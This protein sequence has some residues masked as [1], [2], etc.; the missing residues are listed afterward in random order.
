MGN[1][2]IHE[3]THEQS[4]YWRKHLPMN[5]VIIVKGQIVPMC[6][7]LMLSKPSMMNTK[8]TKKLDDLNLQLFRK[9]PKDISTAHHVTMLWHRWAWCHLRSKIQFFFLQNYRT[10]IYLLNIP[11]IFWR[12]WILSGELQWHLWSDGPSQDF[13]KSRYVYNK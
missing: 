8:P 9:Y 3:F 2:P 11:F 1:K 4:Y 10:A 5:K 12:C 13:G 6:C 7:R